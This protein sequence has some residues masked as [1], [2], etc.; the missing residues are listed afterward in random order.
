MSV[1]RIATRFAGIDFGVVLTLVLSFDP[2][3]AQKTARS[4]FAR[5]FARAR[6]RHDRRY[7]RAADRIADRKIASA[8]GRNPGQGIG[9]CDS[10]SE[11]VAAGLAETQSRTRAD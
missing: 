6:I 10:R 11:L 4:G 5:L 2:A 3:P 8:R 9:R 1:R 7:N